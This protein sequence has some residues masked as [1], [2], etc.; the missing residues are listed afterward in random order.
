MVK[1]DFELKFIVA[2]KVFKDQHKKIVPD[3]V[4]YATEL[5]DNTDG[6]ANLFVNSFQKQNSSRKGL[7]YGVF[8]ED[9]EL[10]KFVETLDE[11]I[12]G[13]RFLQLSI[14]IAKRFKNTLVPQASG[15][16]VIIFL[17]NDAK[18]GWIFAIAIMDDK[19]DSGLDENLKFVSSMS[20]NISKMALSTTLRIERFKDE[21]DDSNYL[22]FLTGLR[23]LSSYYKDNFIG[24]DNVLKSKVATD[25]VMNAIESFITDKIKY[26]EK[27][28]KEIREK[29]VNYCYKH[30][31]EVNLRELINYLFP[32]PDI[33]D[34]FYSHVEESNYD[35]S[36]SFKANK[37]TL[38]PWSK[39]F[40]SNDGI[41]LEANSSRIDDGTIS[42]NENEDEVIIKDPLKKIINEIKKFKE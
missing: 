33:Q 18:K 40:S 5:I 9:S 1:K 38:K 32:S 20:L 22:T 8:S 4:K 6:S 23:E 35:V 31:E 7:Q 13:E 24:C 41:K 27:E 14:D 10:K 19:Q 15:G 42:Y 39:L 2:H 16:Y 11:T 12:N 37:T 17:Y 26:D 29:V 28:K 3:D 30:A 21:N 34:K 25:N 36:C